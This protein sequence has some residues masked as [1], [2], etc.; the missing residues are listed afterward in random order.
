[1]HTDAWQA[2]PSVRPHDRRWF[3]RISHPYLVRASACSV[4]TE[5]ATNLQS[6]CSSEFAFCQTDNANLDPDAT[7]L[8]TL[9]DE[10]FHQLR[11]GLSSFKGMPQ[12]AAESLRP[13]LEEAMKVIPENE[14]S[15][16]PIALKAT[17]GLR[18]LGAQDSQDIL[19]AVRVW[20]D[21]EWPFSVVQQDGV[22]IMDGKD[23]GVYAWITINY[24]LGAIGPTAKPGAS[25]AVMDLGGA[26]TQIVFEPLFTRS[27]ETIQPGDHVYDLFLPS[28]SHTLYQHSHLGYGLMQFRRSVHNLIA[29][30]YVW[31]A[32]PQ[33]RTVEWDKLTAQHEI[34]HPCMVKGG[35]K[36][37]ELD[38]PGRKSVEV[39]F[40]GTGAGFDACKRVVD[41]VMAKD[42]LCEVE[43][44]AFGGVYQPNL[45]ETFESGPIYAY[46]LIFSL[47]FWLFAYAY[48]LTA[49]TFL[50]LR[51]HHS[52]RIGS[53][54]RKLYHPRAATAHTGCLQWTGQQERRQERRYCQRA[55]LGPIP[56]LFTSN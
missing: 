43:P 19:D 10:R 54:I 48:L 16:T 51:S 32:A 14:R 44:C 56:W 38:P 17:A 4:S 47:I 53:W 28:G 33:G 18:L 40:V 5:A 45:M 1:M 13:L 21:T 20:L 25:A 15:C 37:V 39:T 7:P 46:G 2:R 55:R 36:V 49:Q 34:P 3:N 22:V 26:S 31:Q 24:L 6:L 29:F 23:E 12:A 41:V 42:A 30:T 27:D 8:P 52:P 35:K 11:P 9:K 50:L